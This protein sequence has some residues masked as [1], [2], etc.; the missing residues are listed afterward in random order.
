MIHQIPPTTIRSCNYGTE[1]FRYET[2]ITVIPPNGPYVVFD[3]YEIDDA[4]GNG[5]GILDYNE[6]VDLN[7]TLNNVGSDEAT[8]VIA[9]ITSSDPLYYYH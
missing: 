3:S 2:V 6:A 9:T 8:D 5:N 1:L 7:M 4:D